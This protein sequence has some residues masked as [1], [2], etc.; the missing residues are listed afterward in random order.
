MFYKDERDSV[1]IKQEWDLNK[2]DF[3]LDMLIQINKTIFSY[4]K[5]NRKTGNQL[6][7]RENELI[8]K[9]E[10]YF[11]FI[12]EKMFDTYSIEIDRKN[13]RNI[14]EKTNYLC[15]VF[16]KAIEVSFEKFKF[17]EV[18]NSE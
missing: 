14:G 12:N 9:P 3:E 13:F 8:K 11:N 16:M 17:G 1:E 10:D 5:F 2:V 15:R 7:N 4:Y 6:I 18:W